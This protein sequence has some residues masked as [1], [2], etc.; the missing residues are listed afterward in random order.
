MA[1]LRSA[2]LSLGWLQAPTVMG[3]DGTG[4]FH[5]TPAAVASSSQKLWINAE[6]VSRIL[7]SGV[8]TC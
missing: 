1:R 5:N 7:P 6:F 2:R 4:L 8:Q 3:P